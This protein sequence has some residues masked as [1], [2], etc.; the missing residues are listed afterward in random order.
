MPS[1]LQPNMVGKMQVRPGNQ[2]HFKFLV[3]IF[4]LV[5][6]AVCS[7]FSVV[8]IHSFSHISLSN[9]FI[10]LQ[11]S[12]IPF[13]SYYSSILFR[14]LKQPE[15]KSFEPT[16]YIYLSTSICNKI[17]PFLL[18]LKLNCII[19]L[20]NSTNGVLEWLWGSITHHQEA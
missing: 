20:E 4:K 19:L 14:N 16:C 11:N 2:F 13:S 18:L 1:S 8:S 3:E 15:K 17:H 10:C 5:L 7:T 12:N 9:L 6:I